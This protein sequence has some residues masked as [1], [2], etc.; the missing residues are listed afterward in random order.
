MSKKVLIIS[1]SFSW[2]NNIK[3]LCEQFK[4]EQKR[5]KMK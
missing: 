3:K 4:K 1:S 5:V 2:S